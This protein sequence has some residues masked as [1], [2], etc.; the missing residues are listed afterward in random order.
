MWTGLGLLR[1]SILSYD[2]MTSFLV[3]SVQV[4]VKVRFWCVI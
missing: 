3:S 4:M 1:L 2:K